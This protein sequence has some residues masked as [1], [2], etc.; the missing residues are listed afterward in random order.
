MLRCMAILPDIVI[1]VIACGLPMIYSST[2]EISG[3]V[4]HEE[5]VDLFFKKSRESE[6]HALKSHLVS[7][8]MSHVIENQ[9]N[10][11]INARSRTVEKFDLQNWSYAWRRI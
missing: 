4:G 5:G 3:L 2:G 10:L 6:P 9:K 11:F 8:A 1:Q 7:D